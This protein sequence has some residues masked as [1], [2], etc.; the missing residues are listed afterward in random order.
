MD[1]IAGGTADGVAGE[2]PT[3]SA[4]VAPIDTSRVRTWL[5]QYVNDCKVRAEKATADLWQSIEAENKAYGL[6][7]HAL[8]PQDA[9]IKAASIDQEFEV[10]T[11]DLSDQLDEMTALLMD[12]F[13]GSEIRRMV[14]RPGISPKQVE[15]TT[16]VQDALLNEKNFKRELRTAV[17]RFVRN[18][19][20]GFKTCRTREVSYACDRVIVPVFPNFTDDALMMRGFT[21]DGDGLKMA[22]ADE[23]LMFIGAADKRE[24]GSFENILC[25]KYRPDERDFV[26]N[27]AINPRR[28]AIVDPTRPVAQQPSVHEYHYLTASELRRAGFNKD[29]VKKLEETSNGIRDTA[30]QYPGDVSKN[31][32]YAQ[33]GRLDKPTYETCES[34]LEVDWHSGIEDNKFSDEELRAFAV[35]EGFPAELCRYECF[36]WRVWH[37]KDAALLGVEPNYMLDKTESPYVAESFIDADGEFA[38]N[39]MIERMSNIA[40]NVL[41]FLNLTARGVKKNLYQGTFYSRRLGLTTDQLKRLNNVGGFVAVDDTLED[42]ESLLH[43]MQYPDISGAGMGMVSYFSEKLRG[44]GVPSVLAGEGQADTATQDVINNKRGQT[45]VNEAFGRFVA[46]LKEAYRKHLGAMVANFTTSRYVEIAGEDGTTLTREWVTPQELTDKLDI[47]MMV[48][49]N[50]AEKQRM[51]QFFLGL[52]NI[53][54]PVQGPAVTLEIAKIAMEKFGVDQCDIDRVMQRAGSTTNVQQEIE[55][56][57]IDPDYTV[58]VRMDDPHPVCIQMAIAAIEHEQDKALANGLPF[59]MPRNLIEYIQMHEAMMRQQATL[60]QMQS[61]GIG[62]PMQGEQQGKPKQ[63]RSDGG[64]GDDIGGTKQDGQ[65]AGGG[66]KGPMS[67]AGMTGQGSVGLVKGAPAG[68]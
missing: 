10:K 51:S 18:R 27:K 34:W 42:I 14:G 13:S 46:M 59:E 11:K 64:P 58:E 22:L 7:D 38:G 49:F 43:T 3:P 68:V 2:I 54:A 28:L 1:I 61:L 9:S 50:D 12:L 44:L 41:A 36:K 53:L 19:Y 67:A 39:S 56:M 21:P 66:N 29:R 37:C 32:S 17:G 35:E 31:Q 52:I 55:T 8:C 30:Q 15:I 25:H 16:K 63:G 65:S 57:L 47:V 48:K 40:A 45:S 33:Q 26:F 24:D 20:A 62:G 6:N 23:G 5:L 4:P 60:M